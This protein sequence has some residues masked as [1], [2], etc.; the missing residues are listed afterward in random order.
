[1]HK[2]GKTVQEDEY[3]A[4]T[5][6]NY[7]FYENSSSRSIHVIMNEYPDFINEPKYQHSIQILTMSLL[8]QRAL[9]AP[10]YVQGFIDLPLRKPCR[11]NA[12]LSEL[13]AAFRIDAP[14]WTVRPLVSLSDIV[15]FTVLISIKL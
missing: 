9:P 8:V 2:F 5:L 7:Y 10:C 1:M 3:Q 4:R 14:N 13:S 6:S 15:F 11:R 12:P